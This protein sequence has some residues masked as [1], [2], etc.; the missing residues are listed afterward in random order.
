MLRR[1]HLRLALA[2]MATV[3]LVALG[4]PF[5]FFTVGG[6]RFNPTPSY[7]AYSPPRSQAEA[8]TQDLVDLE[9]LLMLDR[10]FSPAE[11]DAFRQGIAQLRTKVGM[12]SPAEFDMAVA[13][14]AA[15]SGNG[16][17]MIDPRALMMRFTRVPLDLAWFEEGL[18]VV[19]AA[20]SEADLLGSRIRSIAGHSV[21]QTLMALRPFIS[22][23]DERAH[24][25]APRFLTSPA[26][27]QTVWP[28]TDPDNLL[29]LLDT[30]DGHT[31][32]RTVPAVRFEAP[33]RRVYAKD[34]K[35]VTDGLTDTAPSLLEPRRIFLRRELENGGLYIRL[36][37]IADDD[38]GPLE[39][40]LAPALEGAPEAGWRWIVVDLRGNNGGNYLKSVSFT[41]ALPDALASNG[42]LWLLINNETFSAAIATLARARHFAGERAHIVGERVGDS[43]EFWAEQGA[44]LVLRNSRATVLYATGRH[45][46]VNGCY[47]LDCFWL[48]F[49]YQVAAGDL[50]PEIE[51]RWR[52]SDYA[53][54]RDTVL[55]HVRVLVHNGG[56]N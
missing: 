55:E 21:E 22:G 20:P 49:F 51:M 45:D 23:T 42:S 47:A 31:I 7:A 28:E 13:H 29:L 8:D 1:K 18:Y 14:L 10:S 25:M 26:V 43:D 39:E 30:V 44:P 24:A 34:W 16:H 46:W 36:N 12:L 27:L 17:T 40:Q 4:A 15:L 2:A 11:V 52:F 5:A 3:A 6:W 53:Q 56:A 41:R 48:N 50:K 32:E 9:Q 37:A 54:G 33:N 35:Y 19:G 38:Y